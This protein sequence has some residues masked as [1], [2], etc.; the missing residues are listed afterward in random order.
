MIGQLG[1]KRCPILDNFGKKVEGWLFWRSLQQQ[2]LAVKQRYTYY[3]G[4]L[5]GCSSAEELLYERNM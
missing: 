2:S 5:A 1:I 3:S 4:S